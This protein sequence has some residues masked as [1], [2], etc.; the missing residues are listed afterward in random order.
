MWL[1]RFAVRQP[2]IVT[3]FFLAIA[4]F[5]TIGYASMGKNIIPNISLPIVTVSASYPGASPEEIERLVVRPIEDQIQTIRHL[6]KVNATAVDGAATIIV[7][8]KLGTDIDSSANDVTQAVNAA[9]INLPSDLDPPVIDKVDVS[10]QPILSESI[11]SK[12]VAPAALSNLVVN[13]IEPFL[14]GVK[15]VGNVLV[16]GDYPRQFYVEPDPGK[17]TGLHLTM[18]DVNNAVSQGNVSLPARLDQPMQE[19]TIGVRADI[20]SAS[21]LSSLPLIFFGIT[22]GGAH[23]GDVAQ[24]VDGTSTIA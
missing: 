5:G 1:T 8:F 16:A 17:L 6:D 19:S 18:L 12:S 15:G 21:Q 20:T 14:K 23:V 9:R 24:V 4:L 11:T 10:A 3:L 7:Q 2:T 22:T 13:E